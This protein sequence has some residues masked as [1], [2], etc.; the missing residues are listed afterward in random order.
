MRWIELP[1]GERRE[2]PYPADSSPALYGRGAHR[3]TLLDGQ[4]SVVYLKHSTNVSAVLQCEG[5]PPHDIEYPDGGEGACLPDYLLNGGQQIFYVAFQG[6]CIPLRVEVSGCTPQE[7]QE[8]EQRLAGKEQVIV[9]KGDD[10]NGVEQVF[11]VFATDDRSE[12]MLL[13]SADGTTSSFLAADIDASCTTL[14]TLHPLS[15]FSTHPG[16]IGIIINCADTANRAL[17][18]IVYYDE[19]E[20][21]VVHSYSIRAGGE[22][23]ASDNGDYLSISQNSDDGVY[24]LLLYDV[25]NIQ[26]APV[27]VSFSQ[28][29]CMRFLQDGNT[30]FLSVS[31]VGHDV[32]LGNAAVITSSFGAEGWVEIPNTTVS[33]QDPCPNAEIIDGYFFT[34][35][36]NRQY[37][38]DLCYTKIGSDTVFAVSDVALSPPVLLFADLELVPETEVTIATGSGSATTEPDTTGP[39]TTGSGSTDPVPSWV[40]TVIAVVVL[41]LLTMAVTALILHQLLNRNSWW[42]NRRNVDPKQEKAREIPTISVEESPPLPTA[43]SISASTHSFNSYQTQSPSPTMTGRHS[44]AGNP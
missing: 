26:Q 1:S 22:L 32:Q 43:V 4:R 8:F 37:N 23:I 40:I 39:V 20:Q 11:Y 34:F 27:A 33:S 38:F 13:S 10:V 21:E 31:R 25:V 17:R 5:G 35:V 12:V 29:F 15:T 7:E 14:Q 9:L 42:R 30:T 19:Y 2:D 24:S 36:Y 44:M 6:P 41:M 16:L 18:Y 3:S 28:S